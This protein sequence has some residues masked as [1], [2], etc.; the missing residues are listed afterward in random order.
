[1]VELTMMIAIENE[2]GRFNSAAGLQAQGYSD[3]CELP[4][5]GLDSLHAVPSG[6]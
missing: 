3:V 1:M 6:S 2:R 5:P 4:M